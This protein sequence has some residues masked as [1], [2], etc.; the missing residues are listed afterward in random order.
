MIGRVLAP[1][2]Y[3]LWSPPPGKLRSLCGGDPQKQADMRQPGQS[4]S[5]NYRL[6]TRSQGSPSNN[7]RSRSTAAKNT[8]KKVNCFHCV[9]KSS[10]E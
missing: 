1:T 3:D 7:M 10:L 9:S 6:T 2:H 5:T 8:R 4:T